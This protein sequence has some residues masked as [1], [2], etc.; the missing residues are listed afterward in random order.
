MKN[1]KPI[2]CGIVAIGPDNIIGCGG[3]MPWHS[4]QDLFF[5]KTMTMGSPCIFGKTTYENLSIKPL[6]GRLNVVCSRSYKIEKNGDV[7]HAPSLEEGIK[8]CGNVD[9]VFVCGGAV[10]YNYALEK[11]LI[12]VMY[13]TQIYL[14][15]E[16]LKKQ[17][18]INKKTNTY[19]PYNFDNSKWVKYAV[20]FDENLLPKENQ[21]VKAFFYKYVRQR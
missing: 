4:K 18:A 6:P 9:R 1:K 15:D 3:T 5:F 21:N 11:D 10:L 12:D 17:I 13:V 16:T 8:Q 7:L 19:F 2:V 14:F 20:P